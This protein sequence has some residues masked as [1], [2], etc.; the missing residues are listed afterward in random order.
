MLLKERFILFY[1][2]VI[3]KD[4][5]FAYL[6][7]RRRKNTEEKTKVVAAVW[8]TEFIKCQTFVFSTFYSSYCPDA[9]Y[10]ITHIVLV[11]SSCKCKIAGAAKNWMNSA[12][13]QQLRP[14][15][16]LL[17]LSFFYD[18]WQSS[19]T[20]SPPQIFFSGKKCKSVNISFLFLRVLKNVKPFSGPLYRPKPSSKG[21]N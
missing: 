17:S 10:P 12:P 15:P 7:H 19:Q 2:A 9:I 13:M 5:I 8:G 1:F 4:I 20:C 6:W 16:S 11:I 14:L 21:L 3:S 18:L